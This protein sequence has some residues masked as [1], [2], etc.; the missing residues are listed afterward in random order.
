MVEKE[1]RG[2]VT[3]LRMARGKGN[4]L[5]LEMINALIDALDRLDSGAARAGILTGQGN[6]FGA[7]V[8]LPALVHGGP[9]YVRRF[10][11]LLQRAFERLATFPK[12]LVAA[13]NGHAI[14]GGAI[15]MLACDQRLLARGTARLGLTEVRV[16]VVFPAWALEIARFAT[17]P[18]HF[19][20]LICT[21]RTWQPEEALARGLVDEL[22]EPERLLDR[23]CEVAEEMAAIPSA[24]FTATKQAVR[25]PMIEAAQRQAALTDAALLDHWCA[26]DTMR[27]IAEFARQTIRSRA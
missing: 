5:N 11:P 25:R 24:A 23:A 20:T 27:Q 6:V 1:D 14:A 8:D 21:G 2:V 16:G 15:L 13:V 7:G 26:P 9:E 3:I 17:P 18:H 22:V 4:A 12:P 19:P 10:V